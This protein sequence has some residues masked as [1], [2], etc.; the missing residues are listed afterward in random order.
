MYV[1]TLKRQNL[2]ACSPS[3]ASVRDY[4]KTTVPF[5]PP[6]L[7]LLQ[8]FTES[9]SSLVAARTMKRILCCVE[10]QVGPESDEL[11]RQAVVNVPARRRKTKAAKLVLQEFTGSTSSL[12]ATRT[13]KRILCGGPSRPGV[14][15]A[16]LSGDR[17]CAK[18]KIENQS[19]RVIFFFYKYE[20]SGL[21]AIRTNLHKFICNGIICLYMK[22]NK[23]KR[24]YTESNLTTI[25]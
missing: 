10:A 9:S 8:E 23:S 22:W 11:F 24:Y 14:R 5:P 4:M 17:Q 7:W 3:R 18:S 13:M 19:G 15:W 16:I 1:H 25:G 6:S 2:F 20:M 21:Q 12:L